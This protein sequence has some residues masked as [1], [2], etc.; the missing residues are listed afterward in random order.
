MEG[1]NGDYDITFDVQPLTKLLVD[2]LK[3]H[4]IKKMHLKYY[5]FKENEKAYFI[6]LSEEG[7]EKKEDIEELFKDLHI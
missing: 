1:L 6:S 2:P 3:P 4:E 5:S 7:F